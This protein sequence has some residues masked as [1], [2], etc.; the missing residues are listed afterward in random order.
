MQ[1]GVIK[2]SQREETRYE[3][4]RRVLDGTL[5]LRDAAVYMRVSYRQAK[6]LKRRAQ[7]GLRGLVHGNRGRS[8][9]NR[10]S[11]EVRQRIL[12]LS[13]ERYSTFNDTH[14]TELL[15]KDGLCISRESVRCI[16]REAGIAPKRKRRPRR[17]RRRRLRKTNEGL[18][19]L[20]DGS[21]LQQVF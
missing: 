1:E 11:E 7:E 16:R 5:S 2:I 6:R 13:Q 4:L 18:M 10:L 9:S 20:W 12:A 14:F 8:P 19:M 3:F 21:G 15:A 17:H